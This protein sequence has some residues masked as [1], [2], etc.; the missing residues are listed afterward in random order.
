VGGAWVD[1]SA[2]VVN[3]SG[4][5][6]WMATGGSGRLVETD[7]ATGISQELTGATRSWTYGNYGLAVDPIHGALFLTDSYNQDVYHVSTTG[8]GSLTLVK[9][10]TGMFGGGLAF[11]PTGELYV[12]V[13]TG[14]SSYPSADNFPVDLYRFSRSWLDSVAAG[15]AP[16]SDATLVASGLSVSGTAFAAAD[17]TGAVYI[18]AADAIY[19]VNPDGTISTFLGDPSK[20][21]FSPSMT[22][23]GFMG[24][25][26]DPTSDQ[27]YYGYRDASTDPLLLGEHAAPE[28]ATA[29]MLGMGAA[30]V[31]FRRRRQSGMPND[32]APMTNQAAKRQ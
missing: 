6:A 26:F 5:E 3:A 14:Y 32:Q 25:A 18:E 28:P 4:T 24:L 9:H 20:N 10:F 15:L 11:S 22:G 19:R 17:A 13:P 16:S 23:A 29:L 21:V 12:P 7:L 31:A 2:F 1:P 8:S 30:I 27:M